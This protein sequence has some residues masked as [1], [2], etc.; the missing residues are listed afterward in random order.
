[1][2][3]NKWLCFIVLLLIGNT[4]F[5]G[6]GIISLE[7]LE[8]IEIIKHVTRGEAWHVLGIFDW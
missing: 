2:K 7:N 5:A 6:R 8:E 4:L 1:M 3:H